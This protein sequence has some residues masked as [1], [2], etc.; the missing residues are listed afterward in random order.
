MISV[1]FY[2]LFM[3]KDL[4]IEKGFHPTEPVL[5]YA[6][7][8]ELKIGKRAMLVKAQ[9]ERAYGTVMSLEKAELDSL[10]KEPGVTDYAPEDIVF[11]TLENETLNVVVY[12][13]S[14]ENYK[15]RNKQYA[16]RLATTATALSLPTE[17]VQK[18]EAFAK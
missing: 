13:I 17:Y 7:N 11:T 14:P 12:N 18:I 1:F 2:G 3:D 4:L 6:D 9:G 15:G 16:Q 8:Y 10:Y 5:G